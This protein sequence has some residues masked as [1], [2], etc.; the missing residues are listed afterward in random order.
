MASA[1][2]LITF[3][4]A[5]N[6]PIFIAQRDGLFERYGIEV[7]M[8]TTPSSIYQFEQLAA[9]SFDIVGTA[10]DNVVAYR[11]NQGAA[12]LDRPLA[13][14]AF[15]GASQIELSLISA[16]AYP[17]L[18]SLRGQDIAMDALDTG[19]AFVAYDLL[20]NAGITSKE[21]SLRAV[22]ATPQR[23]DAVKDGT[24]AATL[25]IE[26]FTTMARASGCHV[27]G[28]S[29]EQY[30]HY[31]GGVFAARDSW[32]DTNPETVNGFVSAYRAAL[33]IVFDANQRAHCIETLLSNMPQIK[34]GLADKV[35]D[36]LLDPRTGLSRQASVSLPGIQ[37]VLALRERY[38]PKGSELSDPDHYLRLHPSI[39][40]TT[41]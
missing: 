19:F 10:F 39:V 24:H 31:Q 15:M 18:A 6:L 25:T 8:S 16:D 4:G 1:I 36:K 5:P 21:V 27:L 13:V 34:P 35:M 14:S 33:D 20:E 7:D 28:T 2:R 32:L 23:L 12:D 17:S 38:H 37:S 29:T 3:P 41:A 9:G 30:S 26:P 40:A 22:G 11:E